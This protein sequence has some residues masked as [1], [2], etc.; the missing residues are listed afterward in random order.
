[1]V[2]LRATEYSRRFGSLL[3][4]AL[5]LAHMHE[6]LYVRLRMTIMETYICGC[7]VS[8]HNFSEND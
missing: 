7:L 3:D 4:T 2:W 5:A 1:M 6:W 8:E